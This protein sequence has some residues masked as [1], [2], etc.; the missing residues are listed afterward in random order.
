MKLA[1]NFPPL[2]A[3][4]ANPPETRPAKLG[5]WLDKA[6][7]RDP[8]AAARIIGDALATTNRIALSDARR[9]ELANLY[10]KAAT[11]VWPGLARAFSK[12]PHPLS[13]DALDAARASITLATEL[14]VAYKRLL[15]REA[16]KRISL[17]GQRLMVALVRRALQASARVLVNS[18]VCYAP[19]PAQTWHDMHAI[20][21]FARSRNL[22]EIAQGADTSTET[23]DHIY[24]KSLLLALANP[25]GFL[26]GQI[27][28]VLRYL[29]DHAHAAKLTDVPPVHRMAKA[30]AIVPVGH[31][32][33][34]F[35]A[36]KGGSVDGTKLFLLTFDLAFTLQEQVRKLETGGDPPVGFRRDVAQRSRNL[37]LLRRLLRQWAIPPARQFSR[38]PSRGRVI[39]SAGFMNAWH[40]SRSDETKPIGGHPDLPAPTACQ[41][42]NQTPHG[43]ALRQVAPSPSSLRI[44]DLI[45]LRS[46]GR[47]TLQIA[48]VRWFR[49]TMSASALEFGC[50]LLCDAPQAATASP[51]DAHDVAPT[52]VVV[53]PGDKTAGKEAVF[54]QMVIPAGSFGLEHAMG[55]WL[56]KGKQIA[57]LIKLV[58]QG[59]D[60]EVYEFAS[61]G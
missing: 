8:T 13:G 10:W 42:L 3:N 38:L 1:L 39:A 47:K 33:P 56:G 29:D 40:S 49:N 12:A 14:A 20:Y 23:A 7:K 51:E 2:E 46:D 16:D 34:P 44:N 60:Y 55:L 21:A 19:V 25:Y 45:V 35:S 24:L 37:A 41:I 53:M 36:N 52:P 22:H 43:Y 59:P 11:G 9:L 57:V 15:A 28:L 4:V 6:A 27:E 48:I 30:V 18:Y 58:D 32:F 31:D 26:P 5:P 17:G 61:V 50:E 54:D